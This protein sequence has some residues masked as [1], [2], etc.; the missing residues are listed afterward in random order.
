MRGHEKRGQKNGFIVM[1][2]SLVTISLTWLELGREVTFSI[3]I[4]T[5]CRTRQFR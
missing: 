4:G 3:M 5:Q 1:I 2:V